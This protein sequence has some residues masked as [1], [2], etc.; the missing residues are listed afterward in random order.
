[1]I[2]GGGSLTKTGGGTL[3]LTNADAA[4]AT[5]IS[6]GTLQLG[7]GSYGNDGTLSGPITDNGVLAANYFGTQTLSGS[8]GGTGAV[9]KAGP[10]TLI[11]TNAES[12]GGGTTISAGTLQL[13]NGVTNG[14]VSATGTVTDTSSWSF[15]N[16]SAETFGGVI[17]GSGGLTMFGA[18]TLTLT[19]SNTYTGGTTI[20]AGTLQLGNGASNGWISATGTLANNSALVF[21]PG[22]AET[23][24][25]TISGSG[26]LTKLGA[27]TLYLTGSTNSYGG[28]TVLSAGTL[29]FVAGAIPTG[30]V[31]ISFNGGALQWAAGNTQ[32]ASASIA[33]IASGQAAILD[34]GSNSVTFNTGLS[35]PGGLTKLGAGTLTLAASNGYGGPTTVNAGTLVALTTASLPGY[36]QWPRS[37]SPAPPAPWL[38][39]PAT[40]RASSESTTSPI[41]CPRRRSAATPISASRSCPRRPSSLS[42]LNGS[43]GFVK[44]GGGVF[45]LSGNATYAGSTKVNGGVLVA[46][47]TSSLA[48]YSTSLSAS[49]VS[50]AAGS[51][52]AVQEGTQAGE[53]GVSN[54]NNVLTTANFA[55][56]ANFGIQVAAR[57]ERLLRRA[58]NRSRLDRLH[59]ARQRHAGPGRSEH[60]FRFDDDQFR[61]VGCLRQCRLGRCRA[62]GQQ[63]YNDWLGR[64]QQRRQRGGIGRQRRV[65]DRAEHTRGRRL[66]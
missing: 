38:F 41:C 19:A 1:M 18:S 14:S 22:A 3:V 58:G 65:C 51:T 2:S 61:R 28:G 13:G 11:L 48:G 43:F 34:T 52:L 60:L 5:T 24:G 27:G 42:G 8:I 44:L 29:D 23:Y 20:S 33:A 35:G 25:G 56:G 63:R 46:T 21:N 49:S 59:D 16:S 50:V 4:S 40:I 17:S 31:A 55:S 54:V 64:R 15:D 36:C 39:R 10:G 12:Y 9:T 47:S 66:Q 62:A 6:G 7:L 57:R 37:R 30:A 45:D 32:D 53:F 26:V